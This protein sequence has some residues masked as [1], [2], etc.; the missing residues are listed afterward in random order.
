VGLANAIIVAAGNGQRMQADCPKQFL[1]LDHH[2]L[3]FHTLRAF[4]LYPEINELI[5]VVPETYVD[6]QIVKDC[7][8]PT[9]PSPVRAVTGGTSRQQ[10]TAR[11][12]AA[13]NP[14]NTIIC[15]YDGGRPFV[16]PALISQT[17]NSCTQYDG[18][19][20]A[21]PVTDTIK[22]V[23]Q[24]Q[25]IRTLDRAQL[26]RA[27]TP[28]TFRRNTLEKA[29]RQAIVE[30]FVGTDGAS[31]VE[32]IGGRIIIVPGQNENIK[33]TTPDELLIAKV[34]LEHKYYET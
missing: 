6:S 24:K 25:L 20:S 12:L 29:L 14:Q 2:P 32:R 11:G 30:D 18:A 27:Q 16:K 1:L 23:R 5:L 33:I 7:I 8:P 22:E 3:L 15:V 28:Q 10:S 26:W 13:C 17:I 4:T 31:L 19:I 21:L 34:I 9:M